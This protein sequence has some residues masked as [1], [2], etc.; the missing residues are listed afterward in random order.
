[1]SKKI[2]K[3]LSAWDRNKEINEFIRDKLGLISQN[4]NTHADD[5]IDNAISRAKIEEKPEWTKL[6]L[7][8]STDNK[9]ADT[10][11]NFFASIAESSN[12]NVDKLVDVTPKKKETIMDII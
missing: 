11:I 12:A 1:M 5:I 7:E 4:G 10:Q 3:A 9:K 6:L 8:S 2:D